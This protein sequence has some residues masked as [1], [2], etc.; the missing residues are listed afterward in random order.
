M[1]SLKEKIECLENNLNLTVD[2]Y[3]DGFMNDI[4]MFFTEFNV[5]NERLLFLNKLSCEKEII[6]WIKKLVSRMMM[7]FDEECESIND[8]IYDYIELG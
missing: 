6:A 7:K 1:L 5:E 3:I 2:G 8:F 4:S